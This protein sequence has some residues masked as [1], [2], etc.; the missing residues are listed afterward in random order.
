[1]EKTEELEN[2]KQIL[3]GMREYCRVANQRHASWFDSRKELKQLVGKL[4]DELGIEVNPKLLETPEPMQV[5][6]AI[7][8]KQKVIRSRARELISH[9]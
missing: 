3:R 5:V 7:D 1:M 6:Y 8:A 4:A 2:A 9:S